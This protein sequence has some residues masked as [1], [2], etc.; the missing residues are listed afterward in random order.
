MNLK[1][2]NPSDNVYVAF[3]NSP[4]FKR[5]FKYASSF[6]EKGTKVVKY[7]NTIG[8]LTKNVEMYGLIH[9]HNIATL[10]GVSND[11]FGN[12]DLH[13]DLD[14]K[15]SLFQNK[16]LNRYATR[17]NIL[18]ISTVSCVNRVVLEVARDFESISDPFTS[19]IPITHNS[20]C[21][22]VVGDIDYINLQNTIK[23]YLLNPNTFNALVI[24][25]GCEDNQFTKCTSGIDV[26][27]LNIQELG[28]PLL[29]REAKEY[30]SSLLKNVL[31]VKSINRTLS[32]ITFALQCG[33][34]DSF[35][36]ITANPLLGYLSTSLLRNGGSIILSE[37]PEV[38]GFE[39]VLLSLCK[40]SADKNKLVEIFAAWDA[41]NIGVNNPAPG[42]FS[43]GISTNLEKSIGAIQKFGFNKIDQVLN[44]SEIP[45]APNGMFFMDSPG[46]DPCSVTGQIATGAT[47]LIFTT[48]RGSNYTNSFLPTIKIGSTSNLANKHLDFIDIDAENLLASRELKDAVLEGLR[49]IVDS[50]NT[51]KSGKLVHSDFVPWIQ[52][53]MN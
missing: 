23:G 1:K 47:C 38:R 48:G 10:N 22:M 52:G 13:L 12:Y 5:G 29:K 42:N 45:D 20:G 39:K 7:G 8:Y 46:Y 9:T 21:G 41:R 51:S 34:S 53:G 31:S 40:S 19:V 14:F 4:S 24:G 3:E 17:K 49:T 35:S 16:R 37:T 32:D 25:L 11:N 2:L 27:Y 15:V 33:G 36:A 43:G 6:L 28:E 44:F 18:V 50:I 30:I 26:A